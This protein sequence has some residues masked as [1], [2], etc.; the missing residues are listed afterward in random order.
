MYNKLIEAK[1]KLG[2]K[3]TEVYPILGMTKQNFYYHLQNLKG[4]KVTFSIEQ[5]KIICE[6]FELDPIIFFG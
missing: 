3:Y 4:N 6:K 1:K 5:L 2:I